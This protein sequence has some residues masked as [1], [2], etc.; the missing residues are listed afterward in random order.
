MSQARPIRIL[1]ADD[2]P[3]VR[4]GLT[5][6]IEQ[7]SDMTVIGQAGDGCE[8]VDMFRQQRPDVVLM[9]LRMPQMDG[10]DA[11]KAICAEFNTAAIVVLTTFDGDED[12]Y[13][14]LQAG[15]KG[16]LLK[17]A[18]AEELLVAIRTVAVGQKYIPPAVGAKLAERMSNPALSDR[19]L[20]V[21]A[22]MAKGKSNK[23]ISATLHISENTVKFHVN[24][25]LGKLEA[26]DRV[27]AVLVAL[28]RGI[29]SV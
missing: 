5:T 26:S 24:N 18:G 6:I 9:D 21:L 1:L 16:Y 20:E 8:A 11:I 14:G 7:E 13:R 22:L 25:I 12:I 10:V 2:H 17:D 28:K 19:E 4:Q 3:V 29:A 23:E 27:Q 15:A